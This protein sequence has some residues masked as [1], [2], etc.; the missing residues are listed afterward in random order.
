MTTQPEFGERLRRERTARG[1]A[2]AALTSAGITA[3]YVSLL[4]AGKRQPTPKVAAALAAALGVDPG[5]LLEGRSGAPAERDHRSLEL[6]FAELAL[7]AGDPQ[8]A[9]Q[10]LERLREQLEPGDARVAEVAL[11]LAS[12]REHC[13]DLEAAIEEL[14]ELR[15]RAEQ[16]QA[17]LPWM[18]IAIDL[19]RCYREVGDLARAVSVAEQAVARA[20]S[21]GLDEAREFPRLVV[22]LAGASRERGDHAHASQLLARLLRALP[23]QATRR[24][25][26]SALWNAAVIAAERGHYADGILLAERA[27]ALFAE[28]DDVRALGMLRT[29]L[30][31]IVLESGDGEPAQALDL[32]LDARER[33]A[34]AGLDVELAYAETE[35]ARACTAL[36]RPD[37][38]VEWARQSLARLG[39]H[40]RLEGARARVA[41][42][43]ALLSRDEQAAAL[44][45][46][47][48]AGEEL[49]QLSAGRQAAGVWRDLAELYARLGDGEASR[50]AYA[51]TVELLGLPRATAAHPAGR[52]RMAATEGADAAS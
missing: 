43:W 23:E 7:R 37:E 39:D 8:E 36:G 24:D 51:R 38:G 52:E 15:E 3:S 42:A 1:M 25:R 32:L 44:V 49:A 34:E 47:H 18:Q 46:L 26:G 16:D 21:L 30:A 19:S 20:R 40:D 5:Y 50:S 4:E 13:G 14:E 35:L 17:G 48:V 28:D 31:W 2:Q 6:R 41:L 12:A 45:E 9:R 10:Q 27:L 11:L 33:L 29:T 22:T